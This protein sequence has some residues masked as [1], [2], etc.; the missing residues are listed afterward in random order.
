MKKIS[1]QEF[2][3]KYRPIQN[4]RFPTFDTI[5]P[6][7]Q[8]LQPFI[9]DR[10]EK[11]LITEYIRNRCF[12]SVT[13]YGADDPNTLGVVPSSLPSMGVAWIITEC[14]YRPEDLEY[15]IINVE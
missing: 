6:Q 3:E 12:W 14:G 5:I 2:I 8:P 9:W 1:N 13:N 7:E 4:C 15:T 11:F 10:R